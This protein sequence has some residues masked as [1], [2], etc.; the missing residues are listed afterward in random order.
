LPIL[1]LALEANVK[2]VL[3]IPHIKN[4]ASLS[5]KLNLF[6]I[7]EVFSSPIFLAIGPDPEPSLKNI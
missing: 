3:G 5:L 7:A 4:T 1:S 6:F 2:N